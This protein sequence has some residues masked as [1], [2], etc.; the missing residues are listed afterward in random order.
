MHPLVPREY[1]TSDTSFSP[2][3]VLTTNALNAA[4]LRDLTGQ[5][6]SFFGPLVLV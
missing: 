5:R 2:P 6:Q 1:G 4:V 3:A